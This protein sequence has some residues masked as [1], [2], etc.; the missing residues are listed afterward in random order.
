MPAAGAIVPRPAVDQLE[1]QASETG[2]GR[3]SPGVHLSVDWLPFE[4]EP[5][6]LAWREEQWHTLGLM[7]GDPWQ[8]RPPRR[9]KVDLVGER[10]QVGRRAGGGEPRASTAHGF[11]DRRA[12]RV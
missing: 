8:Q 9:S 4:P 3:R 2:A 1:A 12:R 7:L 11:D 6:Q 5:K 10:D